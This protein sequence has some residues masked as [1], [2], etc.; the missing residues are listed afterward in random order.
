MQLPRPAPSSAAPHLARPG[1]CPGSPGV[2]S[3]PSRARAPRLAR[4]CSG[5]TARCPRSARDCVR[6]VGSPCDCA[7]SCRNRALCAI[8]GSFR[9]L[10]PAFRGGV[11][12]GRRACLSR[13]PLRGTERRCRRARA[14]RV[15]VE[16]SL[17]RRLKNSRPPKGWEQ[18]EEVRADGLVVT[19]RCG[20]CMEMG[21]FSS[22][23]CLFFFFFWWRVCV[24]WFVSSPCLFVRSSVLLRRT[25]PFFCLGC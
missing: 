20:D 13:R 19:A 17:R 24:C 6:L 11:S 9:A 22:V 23:F 2:C 12:P 16:M 25:L 5:A 3:S 15:C 14:R 21:I 10:Y 8:A 7:F 1:P 4:R 18:I